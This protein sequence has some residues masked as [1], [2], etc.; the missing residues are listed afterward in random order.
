MVKL[1]LLT[2]DKNMIKKP[3]STS[4]VAKPH[5]IFTLSRVWFGVDKSYSNCTQGM[6]WPTLII[7]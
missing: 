7:G 6:V 1:E 3:I 5:P 2:E 4:A